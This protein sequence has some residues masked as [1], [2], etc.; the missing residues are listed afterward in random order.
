MVPRDLGD[1]AVVVC[2]PVP[3]DAARV[4]NMLADKQNHNDAAYPVANLR[5]DRFGQFFVRNQWL[6][7]SVGHGGAPGSSR[8]MLLPEW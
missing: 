1:V 4:W 5:E 2:L 6:A 3:D 7:H 8:A